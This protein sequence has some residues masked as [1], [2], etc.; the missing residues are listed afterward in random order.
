MARVGVA[1]AVALG[2]VGVVAG[3]GCKSKSAAEVSKGD[4]AEVRAAHAAA[5]LGDPKQ[6]VL[7]SFTEGNKVK[8]GSSSV[9]GSTIEEW[10]VEAFN[11]QKNRK[12]MFVTFMYFLDDRFV[13][14]S[15]TRIDYRNN[16]ALVDRWKKT[17]GE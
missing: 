9:A 5:K 1:A 12:D 2:W 17:A 7:D 16:Q 10:K 14:S 15:D 6:K 4:M 11:D 13:D 3:G 8:L